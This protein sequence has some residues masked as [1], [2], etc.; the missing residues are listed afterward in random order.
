[1]CKET[2]LFTLEVLPFCIYEYTIAPAVLPLLE[3]RLESIL[4]YGSEA[5]CRTVLNFLY[6]RKR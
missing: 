6:G 2:N 5:C 1:M 3:A 4:W